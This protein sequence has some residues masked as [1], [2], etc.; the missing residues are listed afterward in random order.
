M[1]RKKREKKLPENFNTL[2]IKPE[3]RKWL[4][5]SREEIQQMIELRA[6]GLSYQKIADTL[7][8]AKLTV[9]YHLNG[10]E[11][12]EQFKA[13]TKARGKMWYRKNKDWK[14]RYYERRKELYERGE[15]E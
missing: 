14:H 11:W 13:D 9:Y 7:G 4:P 8:R 15:L 3:V 1:A 6:L 2:K 12:R 10:D 5:V